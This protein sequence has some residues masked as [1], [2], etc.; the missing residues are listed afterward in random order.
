MNSDMAFAEA[1][2]AKQVSPIEQMLVR[3]EQ[4]LDAQDKLSA[5]LAERLQ[6]VRLVRPRPAEDDRDSQD[7]AR[8]SPLAT[9][10]EAVAGR[11]ASINRWL[12][13]TLEESEL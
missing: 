2:Q 6:S 4:E 1:K 5:A 10:L 9:S 11:L 3:I 13:V 8:H 7:Q 12:Q